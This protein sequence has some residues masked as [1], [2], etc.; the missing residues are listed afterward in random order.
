MV[1]QL[2]HSSQFLDLIR[3]CNHCGSC[4]TGCPL[5]KTTCRTA[6][7]ARGKMIILQDILEDRQEICDELIESIFQC[8]L[9]GA[10]AARCPAGVEAPDI[11]KAARKDMVEIGVCHPAFQGMDQILTKHSNIYAS[12]ERE[13]FGGKVNQRAE[14]VYFMG[15]VGRHRE[16]E[17]VAAC[18]DLLDYLHIDYTLIDEGCCGGVLEDV[19]FSIH[20]D[21]SA[22]NVGLIL[23]A[24]AKTVITGCPYC[25]R[26]FK[27]K[28]TY[29]PLRD[30]G[31][32]VMH[33]SQFLNDFEFGVRSE[34]KVTYHDPCDLGRHAGIY[35]EPR[36]IIGKI[37]SNFVELPSHHGDSLCCGAGGG[38]RGAYA[39]NSLAMARQRLEQVEEVG[40]DVLLTECN[41]CVHNLT[42]ARMRKQKFQICTISQFI[43]QL[44][45]EK[46]VELEVE[47]TRGQKGHF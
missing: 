38:M 18:L 12:E 30:A 46:G 41:S 37:A 15:C 20:E 29:K 2:I 5:F 35:E 7:S 14:V 44:L 13:T 42:N 39:K 25:M 27:N 40:A 16:G 36:Q 6:L 47:R 26:T 28:E 3:R 32:E 11:L 45:E 4:Q 22:R 34:L 10:C 23:N 31:I 19:G 17:A 43:K 33:F 9:C 8:T 21:L 24:G 1:D